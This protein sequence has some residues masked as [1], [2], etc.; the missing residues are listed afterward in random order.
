MGL[1][2]LN[3]SSQPPHRVTPFPLFVHHQPL[4]TNAGAG[5]VVV[6][7]N[8]DNAFL[9]T[10]PSVSAPDRA[11]YV[12]MKDRLC[13]ARAHSTAAPDEPVAPAKASGRGPIGGSGGVSG[14]G[15][16]EANGS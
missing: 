6:A 4:T 11:F 8:F 1:G 13:K 3:R 5:T 2:F 9:R 12:S 16:T 15:G 14:G 10:K 7:E